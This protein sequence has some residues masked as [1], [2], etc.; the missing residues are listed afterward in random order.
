MSAVLALEIETE[1]EIAGLVTLQADR[2]VDGLGEDRVR[3]G[4]GNLL[5]A[6]THIAHDCQTGRNVVMANNTTLAGHIHIGDHVMVGGQ[7]GISGDVQ[8][9][10]VISGSPTMPHKTWLRVQRII[11]RLPELR[12][13]ISALE[14]RLRNL[15]SGEKG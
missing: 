1:G 9:G 4:S 7:S 12:K 11:P 3:I 13:K 8:A 10:Q 15:E 14:K 5:M 2:G 6:Y